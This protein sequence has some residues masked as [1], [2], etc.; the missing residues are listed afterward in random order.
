MK[1]NLD[2][3]TTPEQKLTRFHDAL[4]TVLSVPKA[5]VD[6]RIEARRIA[7]QGKPKR[8]PKPKTSASG[9]VSRARG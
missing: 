4:R 8:G 1:F 7:N 2:P 3:S 6:R 9:H 5:E